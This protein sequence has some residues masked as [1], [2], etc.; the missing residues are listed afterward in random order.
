MEYSG[1]T[2]QFGRYFQHNDLPRLFST[3]NDGSPVGVPCNPPA[4][5]ANNLP[6]PPYSVVTDASLLATLHNY[7][8][9]ILWMS[10]H[11]HLNTVTP[12]PAPGSKGPEYGFWEVETASL[13]DFPQGFR[14][15][16][17]MRNDNNTV[18]IFVTNVDPAAQGTSPAMK[19][20]GY[21]M[22]AAKISQGSLTDTTS[23]VYNAELIKP[24][25]APYTMTVIVSGTGTVKFGPYYPATCTSGSPCAPVAYLPGTRVTLT[26]TQPAG[27]AFA[28]WSTC[29]SAP[30]CTMEMN[31]DVTVT[32][33]FTKAP[34]LV[35]TPTYKNF[36]NV[37]RGQRAAADFTIRNTAAK[38]A[39]DLIMGTIAVSQT[40]SGQFVLVTGMDGCS[41]KTIKTGKSCTF[42]VSFRPSLT[43]TR[44]GMVTIPS[45][46]PASPITIPLTGV[47]K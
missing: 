36:G 14:T 16:D 1:R 3:C 4:D 40:D 22:G 26:A 9:L 33:T 47:G 32:A 31:S 46:D 45:N 17:I 25:A 38:G 10:G 24:L 29:G 44:S 19:S 23:H 8:N 7:P 15:F 5:I 21:A 11:R 20:R 27:Y 43:N 30:T 37:H 2:P 6:V 41:G 35:V 42:R 13:R 34:T 39:A 12:Q 18:S 28:G